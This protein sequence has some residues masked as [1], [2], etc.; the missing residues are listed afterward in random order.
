MSPLNHRVVRLTSIELPQL[1]R[2]FKSN[3]VNG[4]V[5]LE[6]NEHALMRDLLITNELHV[7]RYR[8]VPTACPPQASPGGRGVYLVGGG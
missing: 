5:L 1:R 4:A 8:A 7:K 6:L 3:A 2:T